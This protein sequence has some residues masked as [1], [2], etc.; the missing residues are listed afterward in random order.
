MPQ[1]AK[2]KGDVKKITLKR[3]TYFKLLD[4]KAKLQA[5]TWAETVDK[6]DEL[7]EKHERRRYRE[8]F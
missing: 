5:D 1:E 6:I 3:E 7:I 8:V 4:I 2:I